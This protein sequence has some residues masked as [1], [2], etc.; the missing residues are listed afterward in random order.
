[1]YFNRRAVGDGT[2]YFVHLLVGYG[3]AAICPVFQ[4][5]SRSDPAISVGQTVQENVSSRG[6]AILA[7]RE[8]ILIVRIGDVN[9]LVEL[10][11]R[12]ARVEDVSSFGS[13]VVALTRLRADRNSTERNPVTLNDF[14]GVKQLQSSFLLEYNYAVGAQRVAWGLGCDDLAQHANQ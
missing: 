4:A 12:I 7:R 13:L 11:V 8:A 9:R 14:A 2:P 3:D 5:M 6:N 1:M 10:T